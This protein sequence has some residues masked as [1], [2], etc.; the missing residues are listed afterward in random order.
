M[1]DRG[2]VAVGHT[3]GGYVVFYSHWSGHSLPENV[4]RALARRQRWDDEQYLARIIFDG[5]V[6]KD[7]HGE[8]T[9]YGISTHLGDNSY[10]V[11]VVDPEEQKVK[12]VRE[13]DFPDSSRP[14]REWSFEEYVSLGRATWPGEESDAG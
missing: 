9:G 14:I 4:R 2:N 1:G 7:R 13:T 6:P 8:E 10:P 3:D 5:I 12:L 11:I